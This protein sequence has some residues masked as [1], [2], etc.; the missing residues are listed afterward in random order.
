MTEPDKIMSLVEKVTN[1]LI[2]V[3]QRGVD[4]LDVDTQQQPRKKVDDLEQLAREYCDAKNITTEGRRIEQITRLLK[5]GLSAYR[6]RENLA[7]ANFIEDLLFDP[8]SQAVPQLPGKRLDSAM[9]TH[10]PGKS[11]DAVRLPLFTGFARFLVGFVNEKI[12]GPEPKHSIPYRRVAVFV[13]V[14]LVA[15]GIV[16]ATWIFVTSDEQLAAPPGTAPSATSSV[17]TPPVEVSGKTYTEVAGNRNGVSTWNNPYT[18]S[19][20]NQK[21]PFL[22]KVDVSCKVHSPSFPS[23]SPDGYWYRIASPPFNN[24]WWSPA[25]TFLNGDKV[26]GPTEHN[27]DFAVPDCE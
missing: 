3:R 15:I 5:D 23:V 27:T 13:G 25:N 8:P 17:T 7:S 1:E 16:T 18:P 9:E 12:E 4:R 20:T 21:I 22:Q 19:V 24:E 6:E 26:D 2:D 10:A 14:P 11:Y